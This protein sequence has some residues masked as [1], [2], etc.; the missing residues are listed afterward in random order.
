MK[1]TY[2]DLCLERAEKAT[3]GPWKNFNANDGM[4]IENETHRVASTTV[5]YN[6]YLD[7]EFIANART[8]VP[9]LAKRLNEATEELRRLNEWLVEYKGIKDQYD[10]IDSLVEKLETI[11]D[12]GVG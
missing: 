1:K 8:D 5:S 2:A 6:S 11:P 12:K 10:T 7:G 4:F 9:E 3:E